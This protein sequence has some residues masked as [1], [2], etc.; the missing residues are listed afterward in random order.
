MNYETLNNVEEGIENGNAVIAWSA[1]NE[2]GFEFKT[3][4]ANRRM[5]ADFDGVQLVCF[6]PAAAPNAP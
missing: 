5:P 6:H 2:A 1:K 3:L 4:G